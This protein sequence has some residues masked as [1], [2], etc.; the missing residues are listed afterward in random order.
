MGEYLALAKELPRRG[1]DAAA[2]SA[3]SR[4]YYAAYNT[5]RR[6]RGSV[7]ALPAQSGSHSAVWKALSDS[8]NKNWRTAGN[9]GKAILQFRQQADYDDGVP[10]LV[11]LMHKTVALAEEI[12]SL[13]GS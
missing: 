3:I 10:G 13:L 2:R 12:L 8:G 7:K 6:H 1:G 11:P 9:K 5:A 4:A